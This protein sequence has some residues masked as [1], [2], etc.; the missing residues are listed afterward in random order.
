M[1]RASKKM[2]LEMRIGEDETETEV[3][4]NEKIYCHFV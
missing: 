2:K 1:K 4:R 3:R